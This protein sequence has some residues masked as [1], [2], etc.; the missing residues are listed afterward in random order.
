VAAPAT[1]LLLAAALGVADAAQGAAPA[2]DY[3][4]RPLLEALQDLQARGLRLIY[5][6]EVV[7]PDL[8]VAE[9]PSGRR[10]RTV[11]ESLLTPHG[12]EARAGPG[13]TLLVVRRGGDGAP[14]AI[15][16]IIRTRDGR[17]A[18]PGAR[19]V[20]RG[21]RLEARSAADGAF[22]IED[23]PA[24]VHDLVV[25]LPGLRR[26][27]FREVVVRPGAATRL[28][29]DLT[30][31]AGL[32]ETVV[33]TPDRR[34][35]EVRGPDGATAIDGEEIRGAP[36][37]GEDVH[38]ALAWQPGT[39][40]A[41][42]SA[43]LNV[44]G[45]EP[46]EVLVLL[47]GLE[48]YDPF[49]LMHFQTFSGIVDAMAVGHAEFFPGTFPVEYGDR[50]GGVLELSS[51]VPAEPGRTSIGTGFVNTRLLSEGRFSSGGGSWLIG[52]RAWHT[53][54]VVRVLDQENEGF[55]PSY[56]D[57]LGKAER[58]V[59]DRSTLTGNVLAARDVIDFTDPD[60]D[61][62]VN[63]DS[64]TRYA[65]LSLKTAWSA[66]LTSKSLVSLGRIH[67]LRS[68][69]EMD[70]SG[71]VATVDDTRAFDVIGFDQN[72]TWERE[73][74]T[75]KW[76]VR[77]RWMNADYRYA[78]RTTAGGGDRVVAY[79]PSGRQFGA[80]LAGRLRAGPRLW[81]E[82]GLRW[83][84][85]SYTGESEVS[86]RVGLVADLGPS[87]RLR[88]GWGRY[89]QS[90]GLY[91]LQV[92]DGIAEIFPAQ[93]ADQWSAGFEHVFASGLSVRADAYRRR[94][95]RV[96]P[97]FENLFNAFELVPE[98]ETDRVLIEPE[99]A[100]ARG[101]DLVLAMDRGGPIAWWASYARSETADEIG[102]ERVPR[103]W[104][105]PHAFRFGMHVRGRSPWRLTLAGVYH[106]GW[107]RTPVVAV[108]VT[109]PDGGDTVEPA[110][111]DRNGARYPAY[112]RLDLRASRTFVMP[113]G[114]L[115]LFAD[116]TNVY[117][118]DNVCCTEDA[119]LVPDGAG[120][121][122][123]VREDG[124]WLQRVPVIG[125]VWEF[126]H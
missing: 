83:D 19:I 43:A 54:A 112:H 99:G 84:R 42:R 31:I 105:Q 107:P 125:V 119:T 88:A 49:H 89:H 70:E 39:A 56:Y 25:R 98:F 78:H 16:G 120:G 96:R 21:T 116:V 91:E 51:S 73:R 58:R 3:A 92:E 65:W 76:G 57:L 93:R 5:S 34:P 20:L 59:G 29:L 111:G 106:S 102:G 23:V 80:H 63:A 12:L 7:T 121:T 33:V 62:A 100:V 22:G 35:P 110:P 118:R 27:V 8:I 108:T 87:T 103:S 123:V 6:S 55:S 47:D 15:E 37:V 81:I 36:G 28:T 60:G 86:P 124:F 50:L 53:D 77:A 117:G 24:G 2:R 95:S 52:A 1:V 82:T 11:L 115:V 17:H 113:A 26:E 64:G 48:L 104:D 126:D 109:D 114:R 38:R 79:D 101:L 90:Q 41:D 94:L 69:R 44:H 30:A 9:E 4:G 71:V 68:A 97:R 67:H 74:F 10:R 61:E 14:G 40:A 85:Q 122:R 13:G 45:G 72:W 46:N 18:V 32:L 75:G 66:R